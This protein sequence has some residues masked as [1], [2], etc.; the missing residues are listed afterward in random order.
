MP[1]SI[2]LLIQAYAVFPDYA[3]PLD[4]VITFAAVAKYH[5]IPLHILNTEFFGWLP[6]PMEENHALSQEADQFAHIVIENIS[7]YT[8]NLVTLL[9]MCLRVLLF[10]GFWGFFMC[11][12]MNLMIA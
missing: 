3:G 12:G 9:C 6:V 7:E 5:S 10:W 4:D 11:L 2:T 8:Y 1:I